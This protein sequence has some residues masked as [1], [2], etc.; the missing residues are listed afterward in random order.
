MKLTR[1]NTASDSKTPSRSASRLTWAGGVSQIIAAIGILFLPV[2]EI[3][4]PQLNAPLLCQRQS[5]IALRGNVLGYSFLLGM[6]AGGLVVIASLRDQ[7]LPRVRMIR[8]LDAL[9]SL[10]VMFLAG[11]GFGIAFAPSTLFLIF[12]AIRT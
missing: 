4:Q 9:F 3:C 1:A 7:N 6:L 10:L 2:F 5:Y 8:W 11:F 12:A